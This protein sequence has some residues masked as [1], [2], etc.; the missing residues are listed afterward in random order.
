MPKL[1]SSGAEHVVQI[2]WDLFYGSLEWP[3]LGTVAR[4]FD[5]RHNLEIDDA[6]ADVP[7]ELL[8]GID[9]SGLLDDNVT[10]KLT[11]A[12]A[13]AARGS[14]DEVSVFVAAVRLAAELDRAWDQWAWSAS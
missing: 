7:P 4:K 6:L 1:P 5:R 8:R 14:D 10:V 13:A 3:T 11:I 12:G 9:P 2:V